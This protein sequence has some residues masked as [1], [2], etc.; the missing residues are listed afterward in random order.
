MS[1]DIRSGL[2][3]AVMEAKKLIEESGKPSIRVKPS[4]MRDAMMVYL[5][6]NQYD[7]IQSLIDIAQDNDFVKV[8][9]EDNPGSYKEVH[10]PVDVN[11][12]IG[13]HKEFL[14]F[15]A[16]AM[17]VTD[18]DKNAEAQF[19]VYINEFVLNHSGKPKQ[20]AIEEDTAEDV[21]EVSE[22]PV[23]VEINV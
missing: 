18:P 14:K 13:I 7:P 1:R 4:E 21:P 10:A 16:P 19:N 22:N 11:Y 9:D 23:E 2:S 15:L 8:P 17:K 3:G 20:A 12:R 5:E 6:K